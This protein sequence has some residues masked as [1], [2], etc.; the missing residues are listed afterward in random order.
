MKKYKITY[1]ADGVQ[2]SRTIEAE[3]KEE[4]L[5]KAWSLIDADDVHVSEVMT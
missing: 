3:N 1:Y 2:H 4:A 5:G